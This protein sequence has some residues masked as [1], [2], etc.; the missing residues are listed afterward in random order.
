MDLSLKKVVVQYVV[1]FLFAI[2]FTYMF[3]ALTLVETL[4][5]FLWGCNP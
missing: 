4:K 2:K 3:Q 1:K 5:Q